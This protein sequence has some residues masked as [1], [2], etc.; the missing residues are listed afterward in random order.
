MPKKRHWLMETWVNTW[1]DRELSARQAYVQYETTGIWKEMN[2]EKPVTWGRFKN[3]FYEIKSQRTKHEPENSSITNFPITEA[4]DGVNATLDTLMSIDPVVASNDEI[5][6]E[7]IGMTTERDVLESWRELCH[8]YLKYNLLEILEPNSPFHDP[9]MVRLDAGLLKW[10]VRLRNLSYSA[11]LSS[12]S[13]EMFD[14]VRMLRVLGSEHL[15]MWENLTK[16]GRIYCRRP[17]VERIFY[18]EFWRG[19][20]DDFQTRTLDI[21]SDVK[22]RPDLFWKSPISEFMEQW[23]FVAQDTKLTLG[24]MVPYTGSEPSYRE[25]FDEAQTA[26]RFGLSME[27]PISLTQTEFQQGL[28]SGE[29]M[30]FKVTYLEGLQ[31]RRH[32]LT[33]FFLR[34]GELL[35]RE[36]EMA[37]ITDL[38][39]TD[40]LK[41]WSLKVHKTKLND[42]WDENQEEFQK[43]LN[44]QLS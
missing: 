19:E 36:V 29:S 17:K 18:T 8:F 37:D 9:R 39:S 28:K 42:S 34:W 32:P 20:L 13:P 22:L 11:E 25:D 10:Y 3:V 14:R 4:E 31:T 12:S 33:Y 40:R 16:N 27:L 41:E 24:T 35:E 21:G 5:K 43:A 1:I 26:L 23:V 44:V 2:R 38:V 30:D 7:I 15:C 6:N